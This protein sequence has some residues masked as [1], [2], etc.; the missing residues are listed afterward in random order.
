MAFDGSNTAAVVPNREATR[1]VSC[2]QEGSGAF[3]ARLPV[4]H[5]LLSD[6]F[7]VILQRRLGLYLTALAPVLD[8][9]AA[10]G[11]VI[12]EYER[13]GDADINTSNNTARPNAA[14]HT[15]YHASVC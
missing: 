8:A 1:L 14:L 9:A 6:A 12:T 7:L 13:L 11:Q 2:S 3:V 5:R 10:N 15:T 4:D